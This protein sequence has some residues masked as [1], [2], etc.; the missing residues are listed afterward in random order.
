MECKEVDTK[1]G[2]LPYFASSGIEPEIAWK[3]Q[4]LIGLFDIL[5]AVVKTKSY[6]LDLDVLMGIMDRDF[7]TPVWQLGKSSGR[8]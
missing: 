4:P 7:T 3:L 8:W 2:W 6:H 5:M 1:S